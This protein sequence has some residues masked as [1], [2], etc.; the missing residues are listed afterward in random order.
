MNFDRQAFS[1]RE[2][3]VRNN[4]SRG[5]FYDEVRRGRL[6]ARK[7]DTKTIVTAEDEAA[8]RDSLPALELSKQGGPAA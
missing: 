6:R 1:V 5:K 8:W 2:I 7:V 4:I 3:C